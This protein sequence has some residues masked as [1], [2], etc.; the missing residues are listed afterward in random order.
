MELIKQYFIK[1]NNPDRRNPWLYQRLLTLDNKKRFTKSGLGLTRIKK[2]FE[3]TGEVKFVN[4][5][6]MNLFKV[7]MPGVNNIKS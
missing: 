3:E 2:A 4:V 7:I 5:G 6:S 1:E